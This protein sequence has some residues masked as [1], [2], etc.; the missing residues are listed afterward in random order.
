MFFASILIYGSILVPVW[1]FVRF[2]AGLKKESTGNMDA[3]E[4]T[5]DPIKIKEA[6]E[7]SLPSLP[8]G[9]VSTAT[10]SS[11][12]LSSSFSTAT[13]PTLV[14][15]STGFHT[16][17]E[18]WHDIKSLRMELDTK[19]R[20]F[21]LCLKFEEFSLST[22]STTDDSITDD[23]ASNEAADENNERIEREPPTM[24]Q[25]KA[26]ARLW[27]QNQVAKMRRQNRQRRR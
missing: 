5:K 6:D 18:K 26:N 22:D 25:A 21:E 23:S 2:I 19:M 14:S 24:A 3:T 16:A 27:Q 9:P 15:E 7:P 13:P 20:E 8:T 11:T 4:N 17:I 1:I 10:P 12:L